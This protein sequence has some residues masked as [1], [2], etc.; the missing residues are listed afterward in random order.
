M[1]YTCQE[2]NCNSEEIFN[3]SR[4]KQGYSEENP[5]NLDGSKSFVDNRLKV[6]IQSR[7]KKADPNIKVYYDQKGDLM[8]NS[9]NAKLPARVFLGGCTEIFVKPN[10]LINLTKKVEE[11][12]NKNRPGKI[13]KMINIPWRDKEKLIEPVF[14]G[15]KG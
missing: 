1:P 6:I 5:I 3:P 13:D 15:I 7:E 14:G 8:I 10:Q 11:E 9:K 12:K 2:D 4:R